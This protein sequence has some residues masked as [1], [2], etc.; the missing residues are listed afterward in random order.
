VCV[1]CGARLDYH[2]AMRAA[3]L[4]L[5]ALFVSTSLNVTVADQAP[6]VPRATGRGNPDIQYA[7]QSVDALIAEFM[8][9]HD[10]PGMS[11][12][13]VQA[14]YITRAT[15][16][17][18][19]DAASRTLVSANT[20]FDIGTM[21]HAFTA[22]AVMQL[23]EAGKLTL[24][25]V[26]PRLLRV[27]EYPEL[28][29]TIAR[30]SGQSY[31]SFIKSGQFDRVG[32]RHTFFGDSLE[33]APYERLTAGHKHQQFL[34]NPLLIDPTEPATGYRGPSALPRTG[35]AIYST[36]ADISVWDIGLAGDILIKD[37]SLRK[38]LYAPARIAGTALPTT[39]AWH[40]PGHQG[41]MITVG[42][43]DGFS[44][45]LSRFTD[46]ADLL[47]VTLL[48]NK[49]GLDLTQ[50]AR[51]I[52]GA[53]NAT[54]GPPVQAAAMRVQQSPFPVGETLDRL[55]AV[56]RARGDAIIA[57]VD[58]RKGAHAAGL[59]LPATEQLIF[60]NAS[61]GTLLM[62]ASPPVVMDLPLRAAAWEENGKVWLA[63]TDP[64]SIARHEGI[65]GHD[66]LVREMRAAID[67]ALLRAVWP[68]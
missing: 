26:Q 7:G 35:A 48:A 68:E 1:G 36:A 66:A 62:Q 3:F 56:L 21:R 2:F 4:I 12:A 54:L 60:G 28:E 63:A 30:A 13:I 22:V 57:R 34:R 20:M 29:R 42:S 47:C 55:E 14:P 11:V 9:E 16:F 38:L 15:G 45:L 46:P 6:A 5:T 51:K 37:P 8:R 25:E 39:G 44:A 18:V 24:A 19:G 31:Q 58:H 59:S 43:G 64:V 17:G 53:H 33:S 61:R 49:E 52:A 27:A 65:K 40:F 10:V 41:L 23:V 32:L 67:S 50:L